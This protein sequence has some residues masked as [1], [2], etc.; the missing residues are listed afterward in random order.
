MCPENYW[1]IRH[2]VLPFS[3]DPR[4]AGRLYELRTVREYATAVGS[5]N[6]L[7]MRTLCV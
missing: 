5:V 2:S 7:Q 6:R 3:A 4:T 1:S